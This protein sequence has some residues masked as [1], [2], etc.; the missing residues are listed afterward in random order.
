MSTVEDILMQKGSDVIA[1]VPDATVSQAA[2]IMIDTNVGCLVV[3]EDT[4]VIGIFTERDLLHRVVGCSKDPASVPIREVMSSPVHSCRP[5]DDIAECF[6]I[7]SSNHYRHLVVVD[8]N[9]LVGVIS[10][11]DVALLLREV[12]GD[13]PV[14]TPAFDVSD[15]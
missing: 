14:S 11:R 8:N 12:D 10:L 2:Q 3:Q 6:D 4:K 5:W 1:V 9:E 7:L 13:I 15:N